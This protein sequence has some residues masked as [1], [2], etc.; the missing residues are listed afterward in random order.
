MSKKSASARKAASSRK[1]APVKKKDNSKLW[2]GLSILALVVIALGAVWAL[3]PTSSVSA[4]GPSSPGSAAASI[5]IPV[6][7]ALQRYNEGSFILDVREPSEFEEGHIPLATLIPLGELADR[8]N[9]L[10]KDRD[11]VVVCR[12]GNRSDKGRD[13]LIEA[14]FPSVAN[15]SGGMNAWKAANY[16]IETG[17]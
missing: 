1:T 17:P 6:S 14:G 7:E 4:G 12:S 5:E 16:P 13:I 10:P 2:Y 3:R 8:L 15:M 9:E 11:I